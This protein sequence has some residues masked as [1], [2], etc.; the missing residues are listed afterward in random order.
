MSATIGGR[1]PAAA[2]SA[3]SAEPPTARWA[4]LRLTVRAVSTAFSTRH[5]EAS[6]GPQTRSADQ[7]AAVCP[8]RACGSTATPTSAAARARGLSALTS[9]TTSPR[10]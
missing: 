2:T 10:S 9:S 1:D 5:R 4:A 8:A 6:P 3:P 7:W